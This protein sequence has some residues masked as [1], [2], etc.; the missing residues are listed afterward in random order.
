M[1]PGAPNPQGPF[2]S[3]D[4]RLSALRTYTYG[5]KV[6]WNVSAAVRLD[7]EYQEYVMRGTDG[8]T[9]QSAYPRARILNGGLTVLW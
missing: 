6:V 2:Y 9:P 1:A 4:H 8:V 5:L 3:S 7:V